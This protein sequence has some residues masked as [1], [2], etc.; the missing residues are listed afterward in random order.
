METVL[1]SSVSAERVAGR[2]RLIKRV[3]GGNMSTVYEAQDTRRGNRTVAVKLLNTEHDDALK[4]E[5]FRRETRALSQLEHPNIVSVLDYGWSSEHRCY[6]L[7]FPYVPRTLL[8]EIE[9]HKADGNHDWCWPL[10]RAM[11]D[12]L[13][14][15]HSQGIIHRDVKPSNVLISAEGQPQLVDFGV[16]LLKYELST[17]VTVSSFW[18]T[19]YASP[20]QRSEHKAD[21]RSDMY[22]LGCVFYHLLARHAP[23]ANG[24]TPAQIDTLP[25][26]VPEQVKR[27]LR[28]M[29]APQPGERFQQ[30]VQLRRQLDLT[31]KFELLPEVYLLVTDRARRDLFDQGHIEQSSTQE[32]CA[33]LLEELGGSEPKEVQLS[34]ERGDVRLLTGALRLIC[35]RDSSSP[36]LVIKA[37]HVP[38]QPQ[39]EQQKSHAAPFRYL[40]QVT[41]SLAAA[42]PSANATAALGAT[43]DSLFEQLSTHQV[44]EQTARQRSAERKDLTRTWEAVL[45]YQ[46][47]L[48]DAVPRLSY[49]YV[50]RD[51]DTL[52]FTLAQ[53]APDDLPWPENAPVAVQDPEHPQA[54]SYVGH[55]MG[56]TGKSLRVSRDVGDAHR[57]VHPA[58]Q[59]PSP[60]LIGVFQQEAKAALERQQAALDVIRAGVTVNPRLPEILRDLAGAEFDEPDGGLEFFQRD[61]AEDKQRAVRQALAARAISFSC[62]D[63]P[64]RGKQPRWPRSSCRSCK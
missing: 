60:G 26:Q 49:R 32:A 42:T 4:Q 3:G 44:T 52:L 15:A 54:A 16:S 62:R 36:V 27:T 18:S 48:L 58:E 30:T 19:G 47:T 41:D 56:I 29:L 12:A 7:V 46:Q 13:V 34:L 38:Y 33:F 24:L 5:I 28:R 63:L 17:G 35:A 9:G 57:L 64:E 50:V 21:E 25:A 40:W 22:S 14:H 55:V 59:L 23:P 31:Q 8:D 53:P 6:Y 1:N 39:L 11:A 45:S 37:V 61:L 2:Y 51:G 10:M 20:E 43:L